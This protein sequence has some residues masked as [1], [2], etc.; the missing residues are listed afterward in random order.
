MLLSIYFIKHNKKI[1]PFLF[2]YSAVLNQKARKKKEV[3]G[4]YNSRYT[5]RVGGKKRNGRI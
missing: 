2:F 1:T 4:E 3:S 5:F